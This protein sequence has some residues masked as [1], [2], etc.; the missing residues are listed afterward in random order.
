MSIQTFFIRGEGGRN[1]LINRLRAL[2][3]V[4][5]LKVVI[6]PA[7]TRSIDQNAALWAM[8]TDVSEQVEWYG[9][10]LA[11]EEWKHVFTAAL[12][13]YK[14]VPGLDGGFVAV[15][16]STSVMSKREFSELLDLVRAFG[17]ERNVEWT[18]QEAA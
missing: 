7:D 4:E 12:K 8:L 16:M 1:Q 2:S 17:D 6:K 3:F 13:R 10:T 15:G 18:M 9:Y 11:P 14:V 5:P